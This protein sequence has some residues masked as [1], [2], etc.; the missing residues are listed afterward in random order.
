MELALG[1]TQL[2]ERWTVFT[3]ATALF[4]GLKKGDWFMLVLTFSPSILSYFYPYP[5]LSLSSFSIM[6]LR[7]CAADILGRV[8]ALI[9]SLRFSA[10]RRSA[11]RDAES[12]SRSN[13]LMDG[14]RE[15]EREGVNYRSTQCQLIL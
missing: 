12:S 3:L 10:C 11:A 13:T 8:W 15:E 1:T 6:A 5:P 4:P 2:A 9:S 14:R 7:D